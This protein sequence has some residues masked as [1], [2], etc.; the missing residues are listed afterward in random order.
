[1]PSPAWLNSPAT[2]R[3]CRRRES[4]RRFGKTARQ[5]Q[6]DAGQGSSACLVFKPGLGDMLGDTIE[7]LLAERGLK[8]GKEGLWQRLQ[9]PQQFAEK[10]PAYT[11]SCP[12]AASSRPAPIDTAGNAA[13]RAA[14]STAGKNLLLRIPD[15]SPIDRRSF[16][17]LRCGGSARCRVRHRSRVAAYLERILEDQ[18]DETN[19]PSTHST[20]AIALRSS[21][22]AAA[23]AGLYCARRRCADASAAGP[24]AASSTAQCSTPH[25]E[26]PRAEAS[27]RR[28][29]W[30]RAGAPTWSMRRT[31]AVIASPISS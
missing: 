18:T 14:A 4:R 10:T 5:M 7:Q 1:M 9:G 16:A 29:R 11:A 21:C 30:H 3:P 6:A 15:G 23:I 12:E 13:T 2:A 26:R 22:F 28:V 27:R 8:P 24:T 31:R 20:V 25:R 19:S 17:S